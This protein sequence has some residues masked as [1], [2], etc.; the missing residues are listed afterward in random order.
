M[1]L[2]T[3]TILTFLCLIFLMASLKNAESSPILDQDYSPPGR[4]NRS[5]TIN[6][7]YSWAQTFTVGIDGTLKE[8]DIFLSRLYGPDS[9]LINFDIY[10]AAPDEA[11]AVSLFHAELDGSSISATSIYY[12]DTIN[13]SINSGISVNVGDELAIVLSSPTLAGAYGWGTWVGTDPANP[14]AY[15]LG[16]AYKY[17]DRTGYRTWRPHGTEGTVDAYFRTYVEPNAVPEPN[18]LLLFGFGLLGFVKICRKTY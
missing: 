7:E 8:V 3:Q 16:Q 9:N 17:R 5:A 11:S 18:S 15:S 1:K 13:V 2:K 14:A 6:W 4:L 12:P 10:S